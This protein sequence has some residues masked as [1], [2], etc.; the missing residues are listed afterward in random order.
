MAPLEVLLQRFGRVNRRGI[1]PVHVCTRLEGGAR[2]YRDAHLQQVAR[3]LEQFLSDKPGGILEELLVQELL[4]A[5]YPV[6]LQ[7]EL[8]GAV[9]EKMQA[10]ERNFVREMLP[11]G[12]HDSD[13]VRRLQEAWDEQFDGVEF[14]IFRSEGRYPF[15]AGSLG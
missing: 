7:Q 11:L 1:C 10:F 5:S 3:V 9:W 4:D 14:P 13:I 15:V 8:M 2:P 6:E 12:V